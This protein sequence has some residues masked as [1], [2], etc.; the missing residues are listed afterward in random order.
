VDLKQRLALITKRNKKAKPHEPQ[1]KWSMEKKIE[2]VGQYLVIGNMRQVAAITGVPW[3]TVR[4][5]KTEP[6]WLEIEAELR[7]TQNIEMDTKLSK[8][9]EKSLDA[10][11]DR[12]ENGDFIYDQ[13]SGELRRKPAALRDVHRVAVDT[14][15]KRE[16]LRGNATERKETSQISI[17]EQLKMLAMEMAKWSEK[18]KKEVIELEEVEDVEYR[19]TPT[20][21]SSDEEEGTNRAIYE[22][23]QTGLQ[24]GASVGTHEETESSSRA[25][26]QEQSEIYRSEEGSGN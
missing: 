6:Q 8:I 16:L 15:T 5:W 23:R 20:D 24:E 17:Q 4:K 19:D 3:H 10:T 11:L 26:G 7:T 2:V 22:E 14:L 12:V 1:K 9:V 13:K 21:S 18:P 25:S